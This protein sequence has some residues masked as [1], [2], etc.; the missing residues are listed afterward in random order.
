MEDDNGLELSL[1][2][3]WSQSSTK[4][5][6]IGDNSS[7]TRQEEGDRS[8]KLINDFKHFLEGGTGKLEF[9]T[10]S[11]RSEPSKPEEK[12]LWIS[13]DSKRPEFEEEKGPESSNKRKFVFEEI[14]NQKKRERESHNLDLQERSRQSHISINT[15]EG[16]TA[17]NEDV[18]DS[19]VVGSNSKKYS[20]GAIPCE[21]GNEVYT[22]FDTSAVAVSGQR[23][24]TITPEKGL[25][26]GK[27]AYSATFT[28]HT[29]NVLNLPTS[30][31]GKVHDGG[32]SASLT[33]GY[34]SM[35]LPILDKDN[36][37]G[38]VSHGSYAGRFQSTMDK[39][40]DGSLKISSQ[41]VQKPSEAPQ[42]SGT[43]L[44]NAKNEDKQD[45]PDKLP[46]ELSSITPGISAD[47]KFG[48]SG[49]YPNLP[50]VSTKGQGPNGRTISGVTYRFSPTQINIVCAC[51]GSHLSPEE[52]V[53]HAGEEK[54]GPES[55]SG[56]VSLP[57][58]NNPAVSPLP[59][60]EY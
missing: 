60:N 12:G 20:R 46:S 4:S 17:E 13:N 56:S 31:S 48:G 18:A 2:L 7:D 8:N 47:L 16:S 50:W 33:F 22:V 40:S 58:N 52:F 32:P 36:S 11:H 14:S 1:T 27:V 28:S 34:S 9:G 45:E 29:A 6:D 26:A 44:E 35:Q 53:R 54:S 51:H 23:G 43:A 39:L 21:T 19:E 5:K 15:D 25:R 24:F 59:Q 57:S 10:G 49:S 55:G 37:W 3:A 41:V 30:I 38:L 42:Y